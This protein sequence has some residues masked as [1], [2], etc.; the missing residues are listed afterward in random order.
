MSTDYAGM[1]ADG[2]SVE[3]QAAKNADMMAAFRGEDVEAVDP[4]E[5]APNFEEMEMP[6]EK[7][8]PKAKM[9][10]TPDQ[11]KELFK[12]VHG[13]EFDPNSSM[14]K[15]KLKEIEETAL[16]MGGL[17]GMSPNQF[18]LKIYRKYKY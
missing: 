9:A 4:D 16:E 14:D 12:T 8:A 5:G 6:E 3:Y 13:G 1:P 17:G 18:A 7:A 15:R 10:L 2:S 11:A